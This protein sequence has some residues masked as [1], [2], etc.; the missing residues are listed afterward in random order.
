[1]SSAQGLRSANANASVG[2]ITIMTVAS[3]SASMQP[4]VIAVADMV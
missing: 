4:V 1:M 2:G 3:A